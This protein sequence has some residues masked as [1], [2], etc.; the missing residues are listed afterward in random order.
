MG[1]VEAKNT[2]LDD[3]WTIRL[4]LFFVR[5]REA[6]APGRMKRLEKIEEWVVAEVVAGGGRQDGQG[7]NRRAP[8]YRLL[9]AAL[10]RA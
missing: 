10:F 1:R 4:S 9:K 3:A 5:P 7:W 6:F 8:Q 2:N